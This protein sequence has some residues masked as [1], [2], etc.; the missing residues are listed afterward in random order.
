MVR[1]TILYDRLG[2]NPTAT[3]KELKKAYHKLSLKW[4]PDKNKSD[5]AE[6]KFKEISEAYTILSN[7][8]KRNLYDQIGIDILKHGENGPQI[9][10]NDIFEQFI[11]GMGRS[12]FGSMGGGF[13]FSGGFNPFFNNQQNR[14]QELEDCVVE[15]YVS[16]EDL[17]NEKEVSVMY[18][19][20]VYCKSCNGN[21]TIDGKPSRCSKCN[22]TGKAVIMRQVG[23]MLQQIYKSCVDCNGTG[24]KSNGN[25]KCHDCGGQKYKIKNKTF[26]FNLKRGIGEG[27]RI[28]VNEEGHVFIKGRSNLIILIKENI[29]DIFQKQNN[30]LHCYM[31]IKLYQLLFGVNKS[32]KHLDGRELFIS[33]SNINIKHLNSEIL[34]MVKN[35]G[36]YDMKQN[37]GNMYIHFNID[38]PNISSLDENELNV[39]KKVLIKSDLNDYR[40]EMNVLKNKDNM[41]MVDISR[42]S[43]NQQQN[44]EQFND[45]IPD[46]LPGCVH[47]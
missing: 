20:K 17:Y 30:D 14:E 37:K 2:V 39:L 8:E 36:M 26:D 15:K 34:F 38:Y 28:T 40:N 21:G 7:E 47:Q 24:E 42:V 29:H 1:D 27:N 11:S 32:I 12:P 13:P 16:L 19:Q 41:K 6:E 3:E 31:N 33:I 46:G 44:K 10:P 4:H 43:I 5:E 35:E 25:N 22:G 9:N 23:K 18:K 45:D